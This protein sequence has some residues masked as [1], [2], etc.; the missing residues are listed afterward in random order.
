MENSI[1]VAL[2]L[3][4][5]LQR[6]LDVVANNVANVNTGGFKA[7]RLIVVDQPQVGT[8]PAVD[9]WVSTSFVRDITSVRDN[10]DGRIDVTDNPLDLA[11][12]GRGQFVVTTPDGDRYTRNGHFRLDETGQMVSED[13][14]PVQ[15]A[16]GAPLVFDV[17]DT[18]V[19]VARDGTVSTERGIIGKIRIV[20]FPAESALLPAGQ[21]NS[22][23]LDLPY[24][25]PDP[26]LIQGAIEKSNVEPITE[27]ERM[28]ST[29]RA[30]DRA[31]QM[32]DREDDRIRKM[33]VVFVE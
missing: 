27:M 19:T 28:I 23:S 9:G 29:H 2:S 18:T 21:D 33:L 4:N 11:L 20:E 17:T 25:L 8:R 13:G 22:S 24:D 26:E 5:V 31:R 10:T 32:I 12:R 14:Y 7:E 1:L 3:Q 15:G 30:Y 16:N 6:N